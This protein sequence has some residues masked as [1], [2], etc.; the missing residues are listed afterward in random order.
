M[1]LF[2]RGGDVNKA[3]RYMEEM[4]KRAEAQVV[5]K[6]EQL[7]LMK[8][9]VPEAKELAEELGI[10]PQEALIYLKEKEG[11]ASKDNGHGTPPKGGFDWQGL[12]GKAGDFGGDIQQMGSGLMNIGLEKEEEIVPERKRVAKGRG[13]R[14][15]KHRY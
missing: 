10:T 4:R 11:I 12:M 13:Q 15:T 3:E 2:N 6:V 7:V 9:L 14:K 5:Q 1:G 8:Q